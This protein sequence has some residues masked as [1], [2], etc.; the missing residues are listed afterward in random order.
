MSARA[1]SLLRS[2]ALPFGASQS[3]AVAVMLVIAFIVRA[4]VGMQFDGMDDA[5]YLEAAGRVSRSL[6][7]DGLFP[8]FQTRVGMTY[9]LGWLLRYSILE[10]AQFRVLLLLAE[11]QL[12]G[13]RARQERAVVCPGRGR[14]RGGLDLLWGAGGGVGGGAGGGGEGGV[15]GG[16]GGGGGGGAARGGAGRGGTLCGGAW[17]RTRCSSS[18]ATS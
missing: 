8:L 15:G 3:L 1:P 16:V 7:L 18:M 14:D 5:G 11:G 2:F 17:A 4:L 10:P 12:F 6:S 9:P 13:Q